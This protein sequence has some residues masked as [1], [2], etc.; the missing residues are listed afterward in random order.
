M[1][2]L[3][4]PV[5]A[6][7]NSAAPPP[8]LPKQR[9]CFRILAARLHPPYIPR[10]FQEIL[11]QGIWVSKRVSYYFFENPGWR[12]TF[13][14]I[15]HCLASIKEIRNLAGW[16]AGSAYFLKKY[17]ESHENLRFLGITAECISRGLLIWRW[18]FNHRAAEPALVENAF[19]CFSRLCYC[20]C[21]PVHKPRS[22]SGRG[23]IW[24]CLGTRCR[25]GSSGA[26]WGG[27]CW[28][29]LTLLAVLLP[30]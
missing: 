6:Q 11:C 2:G 25:G 3:S 24:I 30:V 28:M 5:T 26:R 7:K 15:F 1:H 27:E 22:L 9:S 8:R 23:C 10:I 12:K 13:L 16:D 21:L 29:Y 18:R 20:D 4:K 14:K 17:L 19:I